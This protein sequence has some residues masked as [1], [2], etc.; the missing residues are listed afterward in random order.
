MSDLAIDLIICTYNNAE[1]LRQ[2][3]ES[4]AKLH[5]A[6]DVTWSL[7]V[8]DNNCTDET[9]EVV[10][11]FIAAGAIPG[12]RRVVEPKQGIIWARHRGLKN[13]DAPYAAFVDDD[14]LLEPDWLKRAA[15]FLRDHPRTGAVGGR[16]EVV[17]LE[18]PIPLAKQYKHIFAEQN[19]GD[20]PCRIDRTD[21]PYLVGAGLVVRRDV[22]IDSV[23]M[24]HPILVG[25]LGRTLSAGED[26]EMI[27]HIR[28]AGYEIWYEPT[29]RLKHLI[30]PRRTTM[31]Y[32][33]RLRREGAVA[34]PYCDSWIRGRTPGRLGVLARIIR[35]GWRV[36]QYH[37]KMAL[38][39]ILGRRQRL[40]RN[41]LSRAKYVGQLTGWWR[42]L[43]H[44]PR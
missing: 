35:L 44:L 18:E 26:Y 36:L 2:T 37:V 13:V 17:F 10:D 39:A 6:S 8:V 29:M 5:A 41:R 23:W 11:R 42:A 27:H 19:L 15:A 34:H 21:V 24:T 14:N 32:M 38:N 7:C 1:L 28:S 31:D 30:P 4:I 12:L 20:Q 43:R 25:R 22:L 16:V 33:I 9:A 3:L 40:A